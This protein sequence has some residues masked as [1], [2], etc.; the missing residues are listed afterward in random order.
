M[1]NTILHT[2]NFETKNQQITTTRY[3]TLMK[4]NRQYDLGYSAGALL[5]DYF[6]A[7]MNAI[8]DFDLFVSGNEQLHHNIVQANAESSQKRYISELNKRIKQLSKPIFDYYFT[9]TNQ[10]KKAIQFYTICKTYSIIAEFMIEVVRN[11]WLNL[12][13][14]LEPYDY[15]TY[16]I[17][18]LEET[19]TLDRITEMTLDKLVQVFFKMLQ[20]LDMYGNK[21]FSTIKIDP[22]LMKLIYQAGDEWFI[23]AMLQSEDDKKQMRR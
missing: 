6:E 21:K 5:S 17:E 11:K 12:N 8:T 4:S 16:L 3:N 7:A 23:D 18:K 19:N 22:E 13:F 9:A 2:L 10:D 14:D 15:K 20:Q 1:D